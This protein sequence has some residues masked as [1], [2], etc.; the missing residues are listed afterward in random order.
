MKAG[1]C[2]DD[3]AERPGC[4]A[5]AEHADPM[6]VGALGLQ[7]GHSCHRMLVWE[8]A[9]VQPAVTLALPDAL[10]DVGYSEHCRTPLVRELVHPREHSVVIVPRTGRVQIRVHY[11]TPLEA[12]E[13]AAREVARELCALIRRAGA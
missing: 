10:R 13:A 12:R 8:C 11:L 2:S 9:R 7:L 3:F 6:T 4:A 1:A 5:G